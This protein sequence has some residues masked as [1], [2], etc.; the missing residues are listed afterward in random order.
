MIKIETD[1]LMTSML[2]S[3]RQTLHSFPEVAGQEA[4][5]AT[6]VAGFLNAYKPDSVLTGLGGHGVAAIFMGKESGPTVLVRCELDGLKVEN[7]LDPKDTVFSTTGHRCGHDGHM[8]IIAG[9]AP[10][11]SY[12]RPNRGRVVLLFQPAEETGEGVQR[13]MSDSRFKNIKPDFA[14]ALHN[15]PGYPMNMI[16]CR[17]ST[18]TCASI[19]L[20]IHLKGIASHAAEPE[21]ARSPMECLMKL[22]SCLSEFNKPNDSPFRILTTTHLNMGQESFG[23]SPGDAVLCA[24]LRSETSQDLKNL[25]TK[26]TKLVQKEVKKYKLEMQM[27]WVEEFPGTQNDKKLV[28]LLKNICDRNDLKTNILAKPFRWSDDFGHFSSLCPTLYFGLGAGENTSGLHQ[29]TYAFADELIP[30]GVNVFCNLI[31]SLTDFKKS[32]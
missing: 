15:V 12:N 28:E 22:H 3:F 1:E 32:T 17:N 21:K 23:V 20:K 18:I 24:T 16:V 14:M 7:D 27:N 30:T 9:L 29:P 10:I 4:Y 19:G 25:C 11:F 6:L 26:I 13:I 8:A 31:Q 2:Q 5:T